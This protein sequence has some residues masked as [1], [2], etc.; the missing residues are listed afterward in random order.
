MND[1]YQQVIPLP[2]KYSDVTP[3]QVFQN[4]K[5]KKEIFND[6]ELLEAFQEYCLA[7]DEN[8]NNNLWT[9]FCRNYRIIKE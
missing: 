1:F 6:E 8:P 9:D 5:N 3:N 7:Y 4:I 2:A